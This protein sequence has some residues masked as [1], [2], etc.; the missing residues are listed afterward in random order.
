M[1]WGSISSHSMGL[2][3]GVGGGVGG[4]S[5]IIYSSPSIRKKHMCLLD[6]KYGKRCSMLSSIQYQHSSYIMIYMFNLPYVTKLIFII[7][8]FSVYL[9]AKKYVTPFKSNYHKGNKTNS[10][11]F[12]L[13]EEHSN[14]AIKY[15]SEWKNYEKNPKEWSSYDVVTCNTA[16]EPIDRIHFNNKLWQTYRFGNNSSLYLYN[17]F[18][19]SREDI[20]K[21]RIIGT[22]DN[23]LEL[24]RTSLK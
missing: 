13:A 21:I 23:W 22:T 9:L 5:E 2:R 3:L 6:R 4:S 15:W 8:V 24:K 10:T 11:I 14:L 16:I 7:T 12:K 1:G 20:A 19:D 18:Y 17:A